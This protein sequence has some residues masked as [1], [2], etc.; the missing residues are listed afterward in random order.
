LVDRAYAAPP[1]RRRDV[2]AAPVMERPVASRAQR[3][4]SGGALNDRRWRMRRTVARTGHALGS[5]E[6]PW[7]T[8]SPRTAFFWSV[9]ISTTKVAERSSSEGAVM[10]SMGV[11]WWKSRT[12]ASV[13]DY[14]T[15]QDGVERKKLAT[16][17]PPRHATVPCCKG[18][19]WQTLG[20]GLEP[21]LVGLLM[22]QSLLCGN[23]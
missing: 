12:S 5:P 6:R 11:L 3:G 20:E 8:V 15:C 23:R 1:L 22:G 17:G 2:M 16:L 10:G 4:V 7:P 13:N 19:Q 9:K 18:R 14:G 21:G